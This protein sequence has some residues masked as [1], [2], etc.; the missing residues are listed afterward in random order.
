MD[1]PFHQVHDSVHFQ[2]IVHFCLKQ[3]LENNFKIFKKILGVFKA[4]GKLEYVDLSFNQISALSEVGIFKR[5]GN[6]RTL[7]LNNN[8]IKAMKKKLT[9]DLKN[10][11]HLEVQ[12]NR[13]TRI[14]GLILQSASNLL[15]A[16]FSYNKIETISS[17]CKFKKHE[18]F[19]KNT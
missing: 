9:K 12:N 15:Y 3:L 11:E 8:M 4:S 10:L 17:K 7:K 13:I 19:S 16:D 1:D 18:F 2:R 6:I 14:S 5:N